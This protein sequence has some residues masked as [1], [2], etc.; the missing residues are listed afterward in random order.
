M[1]RDAVVLTISDSCSRAE[2][3]DQSGPSLR[4][5]AEDAGWKVR[6]I[7][8]LPD[9]TVLISQRVR[10]L[11]DQ[12]SVALILTTG[13]TG[14]SQRDVTP[15][16]VR[17]LLDKEIPGLGELMRSEGLKATR[18]SPLSRSFGGVRGRSLILC[19][20]GSP[21]GAVESF[22]AVAHL[23]LHICELLD[24]KTAH[25]DCRPEGRK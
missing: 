12:D 3:Q 24:G 23:L 14:V 5:R 22:D 17:P 19:V 4:A 11:C 9:D 8:V 10:D 13:G 7:E 21:K 20:P 1:N 15:E 6:G 18:L 2:R 16:A 25:A